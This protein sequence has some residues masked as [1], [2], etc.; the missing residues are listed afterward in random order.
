MPHDGQTN[1]PV[2]TQVSGRPLLQTKI[3]RPTSAGLRKSGKSGR[4]GFLGS[5]LLCL[6]IWPPRSQR[7]RRGFRMFGERQ[8]HNSLCDV[9]Y[10]QTRWE[11]GN[12]LRGCPGGT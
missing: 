12:R 2:K 9:A 11:D 5:F 3:R 10:G 8:A 4:S 1:R 7:A 6:D